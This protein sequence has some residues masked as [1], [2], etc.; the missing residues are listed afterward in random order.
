M[1]RLNAANNAQTL[2]VGD[3]TTA[4]TSFY[5]ADA[6]VFPAT[7]FLITIDDEIMLVNTVLGDLL[8]S[9]TRAQ[10]STVA[11][12]HV[13]DSLVEGRWTAG[14]YDALASLEDVPKNNFAATANATVNDD[15]S[16]GYGVGSTWINTTDDNAYVCLDATA[17]AA[18]W[19]KVSG[20]TAHLAEKATNSVLGHVKT[21]NVTIKATD[22][23][24]TSEGLFK[25]GS[26]TRDMSVAAGTQAV[27][28]L[29]FK[30][31]SVIMLA[32]VSGAVG[33]LSFGLQQS[34]NANCIFDYYNVAANTWS[35]SAGNAAFMF[36]SSGNA[37][38]GKISSFDTDGFTFTWSKTGSPTGTITVYFLAQR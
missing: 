28:G 36:H 37:Y 1:T 16:S 15:S 23:V 8:S 29:G 35:I 30:P 2:L 3:I 12:T 20:L 19:E 17:G 9:V 6:S 32:C 13:G 26:F 4:T 7:P 14:M 33:M 5:V 27:T 10:E 22:G 31:S 34:T 18:V 24:I 25:V 11:A 21:D 38:Y